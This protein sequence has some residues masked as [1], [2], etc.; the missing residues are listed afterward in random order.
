MAPSLQI[1]LHKLK[2]IFLVSQPKHIVVGLNWEG[3]GYSK[4]QSQLGRLWVLKR[5]VSIGKV[6]GTQKNSLNWDGCGYSKE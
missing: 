3:C 4:E 6:V 1:R 2:I 5:T